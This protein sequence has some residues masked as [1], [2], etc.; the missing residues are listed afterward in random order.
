VLAKPEYLS[1]LRVS[2]LHLCLSVPFVLSWSCIEALASGCCP[3]WL[4]RR[5]RA[6]VREDSVNGFLIDAPDAALLARR[7]TGLLAYRALLT[8]MGASA[9]QCAVVDFELGRCLAQQTPFI[10]DLVS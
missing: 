5:A 10:R 3:D 7:T 1:L 6:R 4:R 9:R 2:S 8:E